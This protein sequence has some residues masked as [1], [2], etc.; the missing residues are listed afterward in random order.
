[1]LLP[2]LLQYKLIEASAFEITVFCLVLV[3]A[4]TF[5]RAVINTSILFTYTCSLWFLMAI[6]IQRCLSFLC[7]C[8]TS[9][10]PRDNLMLGIFEFISCFWFLF[11]VSFKCK[12]QSY[13]CHDILSSLFIQYNFQ[14]LLC[15][16]L[17]SC[18][19][20][21]LVNV[22]VSTAACKRL[23]NFDEGGKIDERGCLIR[24]EALNWVRDESL[25]GR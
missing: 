4:Q 2:L 21:I 10:G 6:K 25:P 1:M 16:M 23:W 22:Y 18:L 14:L 5:G 9:T 20:A 11:F 17:V 13:L 15:V 7:H 3:P 19:L 24:T 12:P 8:Y